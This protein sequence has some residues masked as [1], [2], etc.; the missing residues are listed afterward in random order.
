L[1]W[2]SLTLR[3]IES[4]AAPK[5]ILVARLLADPKYDTEPA[6]DTARV[7]A[8]AN[9]GGGSRA[10]YHRYKSI[11]LAQ[12][13]TLDLVEVSTIKLQPCKPDLHLR[14]LLDRR[15]QLEQM[16]DQAAEPDEQTT[17]ENE[18]NTDPLTQLHRK[19]D[20]AI[21]QE[22]YELAAELRDKIRRLKEKPDGPNT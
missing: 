14:A 20:K 3:T 5:L 6:P 16:R 21:S 12:R 2:R 7:R 13:G 10:T 4:G 1:D 9:L 15:Q 22:N 19:M 11:L 8:F 18:P 17:I